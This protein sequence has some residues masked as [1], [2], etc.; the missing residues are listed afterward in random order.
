MAISVA[1][2]SANVKTLGSSLYTRVIMFLGL[3]ICIYMFGYSMELNSNTVEQIIFW[4]YVE[5][6]A[7]PFVS[8]L[9]LTV[10][11][12]YTGNFKK[13]KI[14]KLAGIFG[15]PSA[16]MLLRFTNDFHH[17]YFRS[18]GFLA[19]EYGKLFFVR[20]FGPWFIIQT[21]HSGLLI[22]LSLLIFI[23]D[24][25]KNRRRERGQIRLIVAA[26]IVAATGLVASYLKPFGLYVDYM[27]LCLPVTCLLIIIAMARYDFLEAKALARS[28]AFESDED[29]ILLVNR[30]NKVIDFNKSAKNLFG[31][32]GIDLNEGYID[33][34]FVNVPNLA[35]ILTN[36]EKSNTELEIN[37]KKK[38]F[39]I[40]TKN[41]GNRIK[42]KWRIKYIRDV[43]VSYELNMSLEKQALS[44]ELSGIGNRR[45]FIQS[46][47]KIIADSDADGRPIH[48]LI[49]DLDWFK[50][51]NDQYGHNIGDQVINRIGILMKDVFSRESI[52]ARIGGEEFGVIIPG[53]NDDEVRKMAETFLEKVSEYGYEYN[54]MTFH[55]TVSIGIAKKTAFGQTLGNL[56]NRADRALYISKDSGRNRVTEYMASSHRHDK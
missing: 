39:E 16:S 22:L 32:L 29:A 20:R 50:N 14:L 30:H 18:V 5:Y 54:D 35:S 37:S 46:G 6:L 52:T 44:D 23:V 28:I 9:W 15:I 21:V 36:D 1:F 41:V 56:M 7:I 13:Y 25:Y 4:N 45:A 31:G 47:E 34:L 19:D 43:T 12:L 53:K 51:V 40:I 38:Y 10:C 27:V 24:F 8:A 17:L 2:L 11:L 42:S 55:V 33:S 26:S 48:I 49:M 3:T